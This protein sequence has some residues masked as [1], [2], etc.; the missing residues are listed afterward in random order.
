MTMEEQGFWGRLGHSA[1]LSAS[2][3]WGVVKEFGLMIWEQLGN[4]FSFAKRTMT[5]TPANPEN[6]ASHEVSSP[7][8]YEQI[9]QE[10][11]TPNSPLNNAYRR[12]AT[13]GGR[14]FG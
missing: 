9:A 10:L 5:G 2:V 14:G 6:L 11:T 8:T 13:R 12:P 7:T 3:V 1:K 4:L